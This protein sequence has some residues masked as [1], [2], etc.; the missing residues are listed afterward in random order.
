[1]AGSA[2]GFW[3]YGGHIAGI[4]KPAVKWGLI[5]LWEKDSFWQFLELWRSLFGYL[6][7]GTDKF[8]RKISGR[9]AGATVDKEGKRGF[10]LTLQT[11]EQHIRGKRANPISVPMRLS[12]PCR[13]RLSCQPW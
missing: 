10:V 2:P 6:F 3:F 9:L 4:L 5:L 1:M 8:L 7:A 11:R 13:R 12:V